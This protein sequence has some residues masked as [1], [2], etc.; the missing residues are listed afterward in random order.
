MT[1]ARSSKKKFAALAVLPFAA[2]LTLSA[3]G[4]ESH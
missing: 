2:A 4:E 3:C 1:I